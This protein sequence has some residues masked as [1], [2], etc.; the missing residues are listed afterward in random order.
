MDI[1]KILKN[2][3]LLSFFALAIVIA[4]ILFVTTSSMINFMAKTIEDITE[5]VKIESV[6]TR[7]NFEKLKA[8]GIIKD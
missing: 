3:L 2:K 8:I 5:G 1:K 4:V 6:T 7:F